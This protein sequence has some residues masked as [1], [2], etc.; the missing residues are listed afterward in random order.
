MNERLVS[1]KKTLPGKD[2]EW[3][4]L[5]KADGLAPRFKTQLHPRPKARL[6]AQTGNEFDI[7]DAAGRGAGA[8]SSS[9][10]LTRVSAVSV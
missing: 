7:S 2:I 9:F 10:L 8:F 4:K 1:K 5:A 6:V 3:S